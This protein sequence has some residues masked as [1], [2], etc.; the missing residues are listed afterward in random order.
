MLSALCRSHLL[1]LRTTCL[2]WEPI[3][4]WSR[5]AVCVSVAVYIWGTGTTDM[6]NDARRFSPLV[7]THRRGPGYVKSCIIMCA[8]QRTEAGSTGISVLARKEQDLL[9]QEWLTELTTPSRNIITFM[10]KVR[11]EDE[12]YVQLAQSYRL[13]PTHGPHVDRLQPLC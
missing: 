11:W 13:K 12:P 8:E 4:G 10:L 7:K 5:V 9:L 2:H 6:G 1:C 3:S